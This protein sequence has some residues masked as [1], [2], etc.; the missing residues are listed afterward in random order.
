MWL[1]F[2]ANMGLLVAKLYG[3]WLSHSYSVLASA[4]DSL[5]DIL[6]QAVLALVE[7][8]MNRVDPLFPVGKTRLET[9]GVVGC[10]VIMSVATL[11]VIQQSAETLYTGLATGDL[12]ELDMGILMYS[13][14]GA[15]VGVKLLL[16]MYCSVSGLRPCVVVG[17]APIPVLAYIC[18]LKLISRLFTIDKIVG[19][20]APTEFVAAVEQIA[21]AHHTSLAVDVI[22]AYHFGS[23]FIVEVEVVLPAEMTVRE[24]HDIGIQLQHKL[25]ALEEV[26]RSFVHIDY[27]K[28]AEPEHKVERNLLGHRNP[29]Q[30]TLV[31]AFP[32][33]CCPSVPF[34]GLH[35]QLHAGAAALCCPS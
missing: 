19:R 28:R 11:E 7:W 5:V 35:G 14:L 29:Q 20:S 8:Q 1:S 34:T 32:A 12:P 4:A 21:E 26:E 22:R 27:S 30:V 24:S 17:P 31:G 18:W 2:V 3:F 10:A 6:S 9:V 25:E 16:W 23:R 33:C 13:I 15:T